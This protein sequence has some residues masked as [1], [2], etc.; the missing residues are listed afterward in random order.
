MHPIVSKYKKLGGSF[1]TASQYLIEKKLKKQG[2]IIH[3]C[4]AVSMEF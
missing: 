3:V 2:S 1:L 4:V